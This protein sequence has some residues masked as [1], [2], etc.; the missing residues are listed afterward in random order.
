MEVENLGDAIVTT[1]GRC[2]VGV[3]MGESNRAAHVVQIRAVRR[4]QSKCRDHCATARVIC[5]SN[6]LA[7]PCVVDTSTSPSLHPL[8]TAGEKAVSMHHVC[9][10]LAT[11]GHVTPPVQPRLEQVPHAAPVH[12]GPEGTTLWGSV[13]HR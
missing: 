12:A 10:A 3:P 13:S 6:P 9:P 2:N 11:D 1:G 5:K 8:S 4:W 7:P